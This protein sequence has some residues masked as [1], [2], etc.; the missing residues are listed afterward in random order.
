MFLD[1]S[2]FR[3]GVMNESSRMVTRRKIKKK[4]GKLGKRR[5]MRA[6]RIVRTGPRGRIIDR[7]SD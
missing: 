4:K 7:G 1:S 6:K 3:E 5:K 2:D